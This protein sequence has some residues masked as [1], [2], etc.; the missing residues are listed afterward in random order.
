MLVTDDDLHVLEKHLLLKRMQGTIWFQTEDLLKNIL[1]RPG[2][3][4]QIGTSSSK[5]KKHLK[6]GNLVETLTNPIFPLECERTCHL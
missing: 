2:R 4:E 6:T 5:I 3:S 1:N